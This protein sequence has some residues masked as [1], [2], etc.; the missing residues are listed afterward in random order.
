[1]AISWDVMVI[2]VGVTVFAIVVFFELRYMR[3]KRKDKI[4]TVLIRDEAYNALITTSAVS[5]AL[6]EKN[7]DTTD[8]DR[9]IFEA[10][11]AYQRRDYLTCKELT[12]QA[13]EALR[14]AKSKDFEVFEEIAST[15]APQEE[16]VVPFQEVKKLPVNYIESKF[17]IESAR[18]GIETASQR[19][20]DTTA[21]RAYLESA[22]KCFAST[23]YTEALKYAYKAKRCADGQTVDRPASAEKKD[24]EELKER[25]DEAEKCLQCGALVRSEDNFCGKCGAKINRIPKCPSCSAEVDPS[26]KFCRRCGTKL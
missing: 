13:K 17:M 8:A 9:L 6:K 26:D 21:A 10:E 24:E 20:L 5:K 4:E 7:K 3:S 18:I 19:G 25:S 22:Q 14:H 23:E 11:R 2:A 16:P 15:P 12:D 1:M